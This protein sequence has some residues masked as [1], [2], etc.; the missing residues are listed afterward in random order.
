MTIHAMF[1]ITVTNPE[2]LAKYREVAG[3]ALAKYGG[4]LVQASP[5]VIV[6]DGSSSAPTM[7]AVLSFPD[8]DA[9]KAWHV[10]PELAHAHDLRRDAGTT[11]LVL[12]T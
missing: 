5:A 2:S 10:D 3:Q 12:L 11:S 7:A 4:A 9:A 8:A 6:L 1:T